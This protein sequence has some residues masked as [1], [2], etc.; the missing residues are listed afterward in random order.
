MSPNAEKVLV[1]ALA[2]PADERAALI[3]AL[4]RSLGEGNQP[5]EA[6]RSGL[7]EALHR[8]QQQFRDGQGL[9]AEIVLDRLRQ[10]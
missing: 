2:L 8:S 5:Y 9:S 10:Q 6:D 3:E 1:E 7:H 4:V